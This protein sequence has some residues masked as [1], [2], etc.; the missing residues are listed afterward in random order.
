MYVRRGKKVSAHYV[1]TS[2]RTAVLTRYTIMIIYLFRFASRNAR[3]F[4]AHDLCNGKLAVNLSQQLLFIF[5]Y[6]YFP[7]PPTGA[8]EKERLSAK[9]ALPKR[10]QYFGN[11]YIFSTPRHTPLITVSRRQ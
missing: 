2:L 7:P 8:W 1:S 3:V 4:T 10:V 9:I 5:T 6:F 11:G